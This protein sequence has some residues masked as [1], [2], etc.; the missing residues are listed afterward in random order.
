LFL[1]GKNN[2]KP[3]QN[4]AMC[5]PFVVPGAKIFKCT[6]AMHCSL[7]AISE[8][9]ICTSHFYVKRGS[10]TLR[11]STLSAEQFDETEKSVKHHKMLI[12]QNNHY[13]HRRYKA[14]RREVPA[15]APVVCE[16]ESVELKMSDMSIHE[17]HRSSSSSSEVVQV[18]SDRV[19]LDGTRVREEQ[20]LAESMTKSDVL[21]SIQQVT[22][23]HE[24]YRRD[25]FSSDPKT[26]AGMS[27]QLRKMINGDVDENGIPGPFGYG[28]VAEMDTF[29]ESVK[30]REPWLACD[31]PQRVEQMELCITQSEGAAFVFWSWKEIMR[32]PEIHAFIAGDAMGNSDTSYIWEHILRAKIQFNAYYRAT[33]ELVDGDWCPADMI[34]EDDL[35]LSLSIDGNIPDQRPGHGVNVTAEPFVWNIDLRVGGM[36]R[37]MPHCPL[38]NVVT[39]HDTD[40]PAL[41]LLDLDYLS[42]DALHSQFTL[43]WN[44]YV[45]SLKE[46]EIEI[47]KRSA[48]LKLMMDADFADEDLVEEVEEVKVQS[49]GYGGAVSNVG[50][51]SRYD[52]WGRNIGKPW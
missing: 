32:T 2:H 39:W 26:L 33:R 41:L 51:P 7:P 42:R 46:T 36:V 35:W 28:V 18:V 17:D 45:A 8:G 23:G 34:A 1:F 19:E 29:L 24:Q 12:H 5:T 43:C 44:D 47:N 31:Y 10:E 40:P 20:A 13:I 11:R 25:M 14:R 48:E 50:R 16:E 27:P 52:G 4:Q 3:N 9:G 21:R 22:S 38:P 15:D 37:M 49:L 30:G 6:A